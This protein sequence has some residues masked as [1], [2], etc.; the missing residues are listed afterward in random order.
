MTPAVST[1]KS[2]QVLRI[3]AGTGPTGATLGE[4]SAAAGLPKPT[5]HRLLAAMVQQGFAL[6]GPQGAGIWS[7]RRSMRWRSNRNRR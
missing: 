4:I 2:F 3:L 7:G 6:R 5:T 1:Q